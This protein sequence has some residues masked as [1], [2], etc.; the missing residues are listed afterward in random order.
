MLLSS[1]PSAHAEA[2]STGGTGGG[3]AAGKPAAPASSASSAAAPKKKKPK[4][5]PSASVAPPPPPPPPPEPEP[6][7]PEPP[8]APE[9][10]SDDDKPKED[11]KPK[12][13]NVSARV[14]TE[15]GGY[16]DTERVTVFTPSIYGSVYNPTSGWNVSGSYLVDVVSAASADIVSTASPRYEEVR[17]AGALAAEYKPGDLGGNVYGSVSREPDYLAYTVGGAGTYDI[18]DKNASLLLGYTYGHDI[19]G[20]NSTPFE[21]F[22]RNVDTNS[23]KAGLTYVVNRRALLTFIT[24]AI[25]Q[26]GDT[27]KPYRY[28][29][30]FAPGV[31]INPGLSVERVNENRLPQRVLEH[32][33]GSRNRYAFS[34]GFANR[35]DNAT[36]RIEERLYDDSW[37]IKATT[38]DIRFLADLSQ[39]ITLG[40][41]VRLHSQTPVNFWQRAY[42]SKGVTDIPA[43]RTGDR[44]LGALT[45]ISGGSYLRVYVGP[46][47][48]PHKVGLGLDTYVTYTSYP[49][50]IY[51]QSRLAGLGAFT[52]EVN[53]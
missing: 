44:E 12:E 48:E 7:P 35:F 19:A 2:Q 27:S 4:G 8:P 53:F 33:P 39:R 15:V 1:V 43:L 13:S 3:R 25:F 31:V 32:V 26:S 14:G 9:K 38:T 28:V 10:K 5:T 24:D 50:A 37:G 46:A 52:L 47:G 17:H 21:V 23:F 18:F 11:E 45:S 29:P 51:I 6:P 40:P 42:I 34:I 49:D 30:M 41:H 20:R 22:A 16:T 36:L